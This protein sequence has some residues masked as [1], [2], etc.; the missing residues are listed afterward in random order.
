MTHFTQPHPIFGIPSH[1]TTFLRIDTGHFS[2]LVPRH[3]VGSCK[4]NQDFCQHL[5]A[6]AIERL[7]QPLKRITQA[8][9]W[10]EQNTLVPI[11]AFPI[12]G[13][14]RGS[15]R[16]QV[17]TRMPS[18]KVS[19]LGVSGWISLPTSSAVRMLARAWLYFHPPPQVKF[20]NFRISPYLNTKIDV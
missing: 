8:T 18:G 4:R 15:I 19:G 11:I 20:M 2:D 13:I 10:L 17:T 7:S 12:L 5:M 1:E 16:T 6:V 14:Y 3:R 9:L